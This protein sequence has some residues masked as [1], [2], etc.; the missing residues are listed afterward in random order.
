M[1]GTDSYDTDI[2]RRIRRPLCVVRH[3]AALALLRWHVV[4]TIPFQLVTF[5]QM[6]PSLLA[7]TYINGWCR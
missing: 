6:R 3:L 1:F 2:Y 5:S 7:E 4:V